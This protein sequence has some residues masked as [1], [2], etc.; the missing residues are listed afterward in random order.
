MLPPTEVQSTQQVHCS[1]SKGWVGGGS[2]LNAPDGVSALYGNIVWCK[3]ACTAMWRARACISAHNRPA[4]PPS[5][6]PISFSFNLPLSHSPS[7]LLPFPPFSHSYSPFSSLLPFPFLFLLSHSCSLSLSLPS[8]PSS[9]L[10]FPPLPSSSSPDADA[11]EEPCNQLALERHPFENPLL[12][13]RPNYLH[14]L[15]LHCTLAEYCRS[16]LVAYTA[17]LNYQKAK[18]TNYCSMLHCSVPC[19]QHCVAVD[20]VLH[21]FAYF[22]SFADLHFAV[23]HCCRIVLVL[24]HCSVVLRHF[25]LFQWVEA[26]CAVQP[27]AVTNTKADYGWS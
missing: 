23:R 6:L 8:S 11:E 19:A 12:L 14:W 18:C 25:A 3:G 2:A 22:A 20:C 5:P 24:V 15:L 4:P 9:L 27:A 1:E 7:L 16:M 21:Y 13:P 10:P 26:T 17:A